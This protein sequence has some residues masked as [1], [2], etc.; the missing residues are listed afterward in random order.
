MV[1]ADICRIQRNCNC[2]RTTDTCILYSTYIQ[3]LVYYTVHIY[4]HLYT[5]QYRYTDTCILY[6][7][8]IQ[9]LVYYTVHIYRHLYTIQYIYTDTCI[10]Y[11]TY[12][13]TLV[14]YT[15]HIYRHLY[16][17]HSGR[18]RFWGRAYTA[19]KWRRNVRSK[20]RKWVPTKRKR[21]TNDTFQKHLS[22]KSRSLRA[23]YASLP[24]FCVQLGFYA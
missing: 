23:L 11:S 21:E 9:T 7:T 10:L 8:F 4:R 18:T 16:T 6:S 2:C 22:T 1:Q 17:I 13:Q 12:I 20:I 15:V 3:T 19:R 14:Y 24:W 5:I